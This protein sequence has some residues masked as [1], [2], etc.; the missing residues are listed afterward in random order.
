[1]VM[2]SSISPTIQYDSVAMEAVLVV[3]A[4]CVASVAGGV[5]VEARSP[6][7]C[8]SGQKHHAHISVL[9][10]MQ[11]LSSEAVTSWC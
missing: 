7:T 3:P 1:M 4:S 10:S 9:C 8:S 5:L 11:R 6:L 2:Q